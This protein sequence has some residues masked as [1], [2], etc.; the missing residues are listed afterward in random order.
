MLN[1]GL[2][3]YGITPEQYVVISK[4]AEE[5]GI[6]QKQLAQKL[7]KDVNTVKAILDKLMQHNYVLRQRNQDDK[8]AF[9]L[10]LTESAREKLPCLRKVD[11]DCMQIVYGSQQE[12]QLN[13]LA[14]ELR[15][16]RKNI[17]HELKKRHER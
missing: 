5:E 8:R 15:Q 16:L 12:E 11:E 14:S 6:S 2:S 7:D 4:L 9:A 3:D 1:K 13:K 10:Y 17:N